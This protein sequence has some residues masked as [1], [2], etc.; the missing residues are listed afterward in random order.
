MSAIALILTTDIPE[1]PRLKSQKGFLRQNLLYSLTALILALLF[2]LVLD[3][4]PPFKGRI[5]CTVYF[6]ISLTAGTFL[7]LI[8][9]SILK[10]RARLE[11]KKFSLAARQFAKGDTSIPLLEWDDE[12]LRFV[13][14]TIS[15]IVRGA[16]LKM[17]RNLR[18]KEKLA[19][20]LNHMQEGVIGVDGGR[21]VLI[22]NPSASQILDSPQNGTGK[23]LIEFTHSPEM[24]EA[25]RLAVKEQKIISKEIEAGYP[26]KKILKINAIG[27][28]PESSDICGILVIND[29]TAVKHLE[30]TRQEFV[31]NASHELRTPLTSIKGFIETLLAGAAKDPG[32]SEKFLNIMN[33]DAERLNRLIEDLLDLSSIESRKMPLK[34]SRF[35]ITEEIRKTLQLLEAPIQKKNIQVTEPS[36]TGLPPI[37]ADRDR[38]R[39][40]LLNLMDNAVKFNRPGGTLSIQ[41]VSFPGGKIEVSVKDN[42]PGIPENLVPRIFERFFRV[43]KARSREEGG[44]GLGLAIAKH[45]IEAHGGQI[46][47]E[48]RPGEGSCFRFIL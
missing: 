47:C 12:Q 3:L 46:F 35:S 31:A 14:G 34:L 43:D 37:Y 42:G 23:S 21:N 28:G 22:H 11:V 2:P 36:D 45:I 33:E 1:S 48:S 20:I 7:L 30:R 16:Q 39:Q 25:V 29:I 27:T 24:D 15:Q 13:A 10:K 9:N 44:T 26:E 17:D 40:V 41:A 4:L 38:I 32:Q 18:E 6:L 19:I 8:F 5:P